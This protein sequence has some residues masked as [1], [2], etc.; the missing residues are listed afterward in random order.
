MDT[1]R[2]DFTYLTYVRAKRRTATLVTV[3]GQQTYV[4]QVKQPIGV[5]DNREDGEDDLQDGKLEGSQFEQE[6]RAPG[7]RTEAVTDVRTEQRCFLKPNMENQQDGSE[8]LEQQHHM[9]R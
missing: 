4:R 8:A 9:A 6:E 2:S 7:L 3:R 5:E 1:E